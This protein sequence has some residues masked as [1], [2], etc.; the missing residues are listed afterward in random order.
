M[1]IYCWFYYTVP[2]GPDGPESTPP[3][4]LPSRP[5]KPGKLIGT[6]LG[7]GGKA[8][9][10]PPTAA[11]S[12]PPDGRLTSMPEVQAPGYPKSNTGGGRQFVSKMSLEGIQSFHQ[13]GFPHSS[14]H[15]R[16]VPAQSLSRGTPLSIIIR[17]ILAD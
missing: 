10:K 6:G 15:S 12:P 11:E 13:K 17:E 4:V 2:D 16:R 9:R 8:P 3:P 5:S 14:S 7:P 1:I